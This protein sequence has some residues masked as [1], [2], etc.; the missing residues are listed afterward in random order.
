M[1]KLIIKGAIYTDGDTLLRPHYSGEYHT[2]DC[3]EYK[4]E[5]EIRANYSEEFANECIEESTT[6]EFDGKTYYQC[7]YS[8]YHTENMELLSDLS[9]LEYYDEQTNF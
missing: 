8:P 7:E 9:D 5:D 2:V 3:T 1:S 4:T 6:L